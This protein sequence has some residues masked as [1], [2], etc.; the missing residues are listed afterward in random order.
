M[1]SK[2]EAVNTIKSILQKIKK[3][4]VVAQQLSDATNIIEDVGLDSLEMLQFML[5]VE[6]T[7]AIMIDFDQIEYEHLYA[8]STLAEF[9]ITMPPRSLTSSQ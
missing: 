2:Q 6:E 8:I 9:L 7:M 3:S 1:I 4:A 5:E